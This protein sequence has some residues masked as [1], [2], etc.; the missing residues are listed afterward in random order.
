MNPN[1]K[2]QHDSSQ[3]VNDSTR[4]RG[5]R[6]CLS[7]DRQHSNPSHCGHKILNSNPQRQDDCRS[8]M[9]SGVGTAKNLPPRQVLSHH[10]RVHW[11]T[12]FSLKFG[13]SQNSDDQQETTRNR[14]GHNLRTNQQR[15]DLT[16]RRRCKIYNNSNHP[17]TLKLQCR[18]AS[19][20]QRNLYTFTRR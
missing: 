12:S 11:M 14:A 15:L 4:Y 8:K 19:R 1:S 7:S 10:R 9:I 16:S 3:G 5:S 6:Q 2:D 20:S 13:K 17:I 18:T